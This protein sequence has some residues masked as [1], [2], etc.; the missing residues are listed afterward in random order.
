M[1]S[2]AAAYLEIQP[3]ILAVLPA[4]EC[5]LVARELAAVADAGVRT[6]GDDPSCLPSRALRCRR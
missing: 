5:E 2:A 4:F 1:S 6:F 3:N